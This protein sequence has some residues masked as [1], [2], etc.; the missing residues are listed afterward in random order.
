MTLVWCLL[1]GMAQAQPQP[2]RVAVLENAPPLGYRDAEGN[3]TGFAINIARALCAEIG[4]RCEF[5]ATR[6]ESLIERLAALGA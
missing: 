4:A 5:E 3:L 6:L 1:A 2:I